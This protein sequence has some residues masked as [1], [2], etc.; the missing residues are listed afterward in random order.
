MEQVCSQCRKRLKHKRPHGVN[1][2]TSD[3]VPR[4]VLGATIP[5]SWMRVINDEA[6][7]RDEYVSTIVREAMAEWIVKHKDES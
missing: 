3:G 7:R 5:E 2:H 4:V 1:G 6:V